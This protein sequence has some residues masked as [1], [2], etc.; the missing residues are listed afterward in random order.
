MNFGDIRDGES[1]FLDA[2]TLVYHFSSHPTFGA[3]CRELI[4]RIARGELRGSTSSHV[5]SNVAHRLMTIE[6]TL[7]VAELTVS[8]IPHIVTWTAICDIRVG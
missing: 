6:A 5:L 7:F 1:V 3:A 8:V 2:N 4:E